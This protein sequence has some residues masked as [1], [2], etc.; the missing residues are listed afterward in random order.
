MSSWASSPSGTTRGAA[1]SNL[2]RC[3]E[4]AVAKKKCPSPIRAGCRNGRG[5]F[6]ATWARCRATGRGWPPL[7]KRLFRMARLGAGDFAR[8]AAELC[9]AIELR[10]ASL[11]RCLGAANNTISEP[12]WPEGIAANPILLFRQAAGSAPRLSGHV[13]IVPPPSVDRREPGRRASRLGKRGMALFACRRAKGTSGGRGPSG[14][15]GPGPV[16]AQFGGVPE[17]TRALDRRPSSR[18]HIP[19]NSRRAIMPPHPSKGERRLL[20]LPQKESGAA[21]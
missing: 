12:I 8:A 10:T 19:Q 5:L 6:G 2:Y 15:V 18:R 1:G 20:P 21:R 16:L 11:R 3:A 4:R 9:I 13:F 7:S 17:A 14:P